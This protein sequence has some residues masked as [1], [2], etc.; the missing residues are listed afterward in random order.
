MATRKSNGA[1]RPSGGMQ[2]SRWASLLFAGLVLLFIG[3][4]IGLQMGAQHPRAALDAQKAAPRVVVTQPPQ[5]VAREI[6]VPA[7]KAEPPPA[8]KGE[9]SPPV[10]AEPLLG[11]GR[12]DV[13]P[14]LD[15][16][17][18]RIEVEAPK[19]RQPVVPP[20]PALPPQ[21]AQPNPTPPPATVAERIVPPSPP[22]VTPASMA[23]P[24]AGS[25]W[26]KFAVTP[27]K[28]DGKAMIA[29]VIDDLGVDRKRSE[30]IMALPA[31]LTTAFMSY[32][33]DLPRLTALARAKGHELMLHMP[34]EPMGASY[35]AG[36]TGDVLTV[37]LPAADIRRRVAE[38]LGRFDGM[39]GLNN[40]MGSRFTADT[41]G[42]KIVMEE[43]AKRGLMF[44]DSVTTQRSVGVEE[45]RRHG[46][47]ALA[48]DVF[49]DNE[50]TLEA[51]TVQLRKAEQVARKQGYAV[52]IGHPHD[53]TIEA[54]TAWLPTLKDKGLVL[55]PISAILRR[56]HPNG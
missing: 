19:Q 36:P 38:G 24:S 23:L 8:V 39:I 51:V 49:I 5:V 47:A 4:L 44:L 31:P 14:A 17:L 34:M 21:T 50:E 10:K 7:P 42:M 56:Q 41:A 16:E 29:V 11:A 45:A 46:I 32:A 6:P 55:V 15:A 25:G 27:P 28:I 20:I 3:F 13:I 26:R 22:Q 12:T 2:V 40:H 18:D 1:K 30:R 37:G 43:L 52:A 53:A 9:P 54:L 48:R 35:D 33:K